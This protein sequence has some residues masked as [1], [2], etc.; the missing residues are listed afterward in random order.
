LLQR[1]HLTPVAMH[2]PLEALEDDVERVVAEADT[3]GCPVIVLPWIPEERRASGQDWIDAARLMNQIGGRIRQLGK[4]FAYHNHDMEFMP[5][6]ELGTG[7]AAL[8]RETDPALVEF[9]VD[10]FWVTKAEQSVPALLAQLGNRVTLCHI[11]DMTNDA[12]RTFAPVGSGT[13]PWKEWLPLLSS[14]MLIVEQ[15]VCKDP[16]PFNCLKASLDFLRTF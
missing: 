16:D 8:I 6:P 5:V 7:Y 15:D 12:E 2:V 13:L 4:R 14:Q 3:I 11:K 1:Y 10:L 9:E